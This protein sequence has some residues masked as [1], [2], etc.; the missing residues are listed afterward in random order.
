VGSSYYSERTTFNL[1]KINR[2]RVFSHACYVLHNREDA[3]DVTQEVF[4]KLWERGK[5]INPDKA[6]GRDIAETSSK[7]EM[8]ENNDWSGIQYFSVIS[9]LRSDIFLSQCLRC[10]SVL[11]DPCIG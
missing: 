4:V 9:S 5:E 7:A 2:D 10:S 1:L 8:I 11:N 6:D 3:E